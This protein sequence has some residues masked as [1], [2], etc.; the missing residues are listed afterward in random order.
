MS[1][2]N[3]KRGE[4]RRRTLIVGAGTPSDPPEIPEIEPEGIPVEP[5]E[6]IPQP[7]KGPFNPDE[8]EQIPPLPIPEHPS[9]GPVNPG[10]PTMRCALS[11]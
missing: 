6:T 11:C 10:Q 8:P 2:Q 9:P 7:D 1:I 5:P 4:W 3:D